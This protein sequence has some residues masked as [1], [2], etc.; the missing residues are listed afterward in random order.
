[1]VKPAIINIAEA[2]IPYEQQSDDSLITLFQNGE[3]AVFRFLV[4]RYQERIRNLIFSIFNDSQIVDDLS[5]EVFVKVY[6]ALPNFR[7]QSS[8]YTWLYRITVNKSRDEIRKKKVKK[9]FMFGVF[10]NEDYHSSDPALQVN[11]DHDDTK[12]LIEK[13]LQK[14]PEKFKMPVILKDIDGLSYEEIA[15]VLACEVGTVKSR[16][17]RG[18]MML[19]EML[20]PY[21]KN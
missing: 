3:K 15:E 2:D 17:S 12:E 5:Q 4:E 9:I 19:K 16:L 10:D 18:R 14:L 13:A 11:F 7:F 20:K 8:F 1:M 21:F 6:E